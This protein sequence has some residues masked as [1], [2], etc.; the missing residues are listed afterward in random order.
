MSL[1]LPEPTATDG[2]VPG[3][4]RGEPL[5]VLV[6]G[7]HEGVRREAVRPPGRLPGRLQLALDLLASDPPG[8][9]VGDN[10][11]GPIPEAA[12]EDLRDRAERPLADGDLPVSVASW[13]PP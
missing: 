2:V 7:R 11:R 3:E 1:R 12:P 6:V 5:D 8:G 9:R 13:A 10:D 4:R